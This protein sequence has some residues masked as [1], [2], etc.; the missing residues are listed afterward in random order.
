MLFVLDGFD[1]LPAKL[2]DNSFIVELIQGKHLPACTVVVTSR[3]AATADFLISC[4]AQINKHIEVL[5]FTHERIKQ[6]AKSILSD[7]PDMLK[8]F[9]QY[10]S[11]NPAIHGMMY[12]PLNSA[13]VLEIY[14]AN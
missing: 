13:I 9:F 3:P 4:K 2:R 12:I 6:Y 10:I 5:G 14:P 11:N 1:E 7:H 8:D